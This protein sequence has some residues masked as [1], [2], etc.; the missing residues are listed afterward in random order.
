MPSDVNPADIASRGLAPSK[1]NSAALWF[2]GPPFLCKTRD[3]W[4]CQPDFVYDL[5][6]SDPDV[7]KISRKRCDAHLHVPEENYLDRL[8]ARYS[9]LERLKST[10]AWILRFKRF[11]ARKYSKATTPSPPVG[12]LTVEERN[13]ALMV[14]VKSTQEQAFP[15]VFSCLPDQNAESA[16]ESVITQELLKNNPE[17][18]KVQALSPFVVRGFLRVGGRLRNA[19]VPF[20]AKQPLLM[21]KNHPV[22]DLLIKRHHEK[23]GHMG[24]NHVLA[25]VNKRFWIVSGRSAARRVLDS[26]SVCRFW[27]AREGSNK[28]ETYLPQELKLSDLLILLAWTLWVLYG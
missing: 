27:K 20:E 6:D 28:W 10:I 3:M 15:N 8:F 14:I 25:D 22:T 12:S 17:L 19:S 16:P 4:S 21:L 7:K 2:R 11:F 13:Q 26:C 18:R 24:V 1:I 5:C 23:E 9:N